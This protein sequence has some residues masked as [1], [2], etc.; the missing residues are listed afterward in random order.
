MVCCLQL[1]P[2]Y[3][4]ALVSVIYEESVIAGKFGT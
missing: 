1:L 2:K 3:L 4:I